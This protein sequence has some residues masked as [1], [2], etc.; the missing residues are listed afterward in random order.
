MKKRRQYMPDNFINA[1]QYLI[2]RAEF[3]DS[4]EIPLKDLLNPKFMER[5]SNTEFFDDF[6]KQGE[7]SINHHNNVGGIPVDSLNK[8]V[9]ETTD[10]NTFDDMISAATDEFLKGCIFL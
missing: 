1:F 10:F 9:S 5:H 3:L 6:F 2:E 7:F 8:Y 4:V